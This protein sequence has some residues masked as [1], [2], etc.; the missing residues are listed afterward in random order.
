MEEVAVRDLPRGRVEEWA[1]I[2]S[3]GGGLGDGIFEG[4]KD[5]EKGLCELRGG[6]GV[7]GLEEHEEGASEIVIVL[8]VFE[9]G[10]ISGFE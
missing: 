3:L 1:D 10:N 2:P 6:G 5:T 7:P 9:L 4:S 8:S